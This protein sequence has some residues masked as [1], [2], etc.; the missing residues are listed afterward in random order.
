MKPG[1]ALYAVSV[2]IKTAG[3]ALPSCVSFSVMTGSGRYLYYRQP[4]VN[5]KFCC[6]DLHSPPGNAASRPYSS[7][8]NSAYN[9][10]RIFSDRL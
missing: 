7:Y 4:D 10:Q 2:G 3:I 8:S 1:L 6:D 9:R 5:G